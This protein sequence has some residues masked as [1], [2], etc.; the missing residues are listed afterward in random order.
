MIT[1]SQ[2]LEEIEMLQ[3]QYPPEFQ[4]TKDYKKAEKR[5]KLLRTCATYL[6][7]SPTHDVLKRELESVENKIKSAENGYN[8][9]YKNTTI[10]ERGKNPKQTY[11]NEMG[12]RTLELQR[13]SLIFLL[14]EQN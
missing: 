8:T 7:F 3:S 14:S 11:R 9:W 12:M 6:E 4:G 5:A 10:E 13:R 2:I 1:K